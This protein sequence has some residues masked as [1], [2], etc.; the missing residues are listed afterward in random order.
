MSYPGHS[1]AGGLTGQA[2]RRDSVSL[3][4]EFFTIALT[5][6]SLESER[7]QVSRIRLRVLI[8]LHNNLDDL[9]SFFELLFFHSFFQAFGDHSPVLYIFLG[10]LAKSKYLSIFS[11]SFTFIQWLS[12]RRPIVFYSFFFFIF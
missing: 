12:T 8:V 7:Q 2:F 11:L 9:D 5:G 3:L 4:W 6:F 10:L 1:L